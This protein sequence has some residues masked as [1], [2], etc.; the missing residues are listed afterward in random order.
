MILMSQV[1]SE[2]NG[3]TAILFI[4]LTVKVLRHFFFK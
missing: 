4:F 3:V 2:S 1:M